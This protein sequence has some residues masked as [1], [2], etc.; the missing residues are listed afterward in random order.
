MFASL[1]YWRTRRVWHT[2]ASH[3]SVHMFHPPNP[4]FLP[5]GEEIFFHST[6]SSGEY[7]ALGRRMVCCRGGS[8]QFFAACCVQ[9]RPHCLYLRA[10][11]NCKCFVVGNRALR[12]DFPFAIPRWGSRDGALDVFLIHEEHA[13]RFAS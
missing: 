10:A 11:V 1:Q 3:D 7:S 12:F 6:P 9:C 13:R 2:R 5:T 8:R 4:C